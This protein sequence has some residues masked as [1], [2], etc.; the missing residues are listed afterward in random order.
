MAIVIKT[1][2][3]PGGK[4]VYDRETNSLLSVME[5]EYVA[6]QRVET[7]T[8]TDDDWELLKRYKDQGYLQDSCLKE[9]VHPATQFLPFYLDSGIKQL[10][11]QCTQECNLRC[12]YCAY[13]GGYDNQRT[14][15]GKKMTPDTMRK[16]IDFLMAHSRGI[17][18]VS[19]GYY[20]GESLLELDLI[21]ESIAYINEK[22]DGRGVKYTLTTN[23]TCFNDDIINFLEENEFNVQISIDGPRE[24]H[25]KNRRYPNGKG[26]Y[27]DI[28]DNVRYIKQNYPEFYRKVGF[29]TVVAP[30]VDLSCVNEFF[31]ADD[32]LSQNNVI[33]NMVNT[34]G[35]SNEIVYDD[36]YHT[37][38]TYHELK[39][40]LAATGLYSKEKL[41][42]LFATAI[43]NLERLHKGLSRLLITEKSHPG[44]PCIPGAMRPF[45]DT[46]GRIFP[47]ER[48]SESLAV[49]IGHIDTGFD[50]NKVEA[51]LN[52]GKLTED[53]CKSCWCFMHCSLCVAACSDGDNLS[54]ETK[55]TYCDS[56]RDTTLASLASLCF[57]MESNYD[58][59]KYKTVKKEGREFQ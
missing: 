18:E 7:G 33:N 47:C 1:F 48:V 2:S 43:G 27:D 45:V 26:S 37:T 56:V 17:D 46:D 20:G 57:L 50:K 59:E 22:Y 30:G 41:S 40:L 58:F 12:S 39:H 31:T 10:T 15:S 36:L 34:F 44:G 35:A 25:D 28:M 13:G 9:I 16:S 24:I 32:V 8:A 55:L 5:E 14:H 51:I 6:C 54:R 52:V 49:Q 53:E 4:Y 21:R 29:I 19:I 42:K 3:T 38:N 23:G 11:L